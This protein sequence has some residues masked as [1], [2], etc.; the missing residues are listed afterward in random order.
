MIGFDQSARARQL[1]DRRKRAKMFRLYPF[2]IILEGC[3]VGAV[4]AVEIKVDSGGRTT[5]GWT[6]LRFY[7]GKIMKDI[8]KFMEDIGAL[9]LLKRGGI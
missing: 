7:H 5:P 1:L 6:I 3:A 2:T 9:S 4:Q 8:D